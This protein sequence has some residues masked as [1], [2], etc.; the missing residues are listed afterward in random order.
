MDKEKYKVKPCVICAKNNVFN[1][2]IISVDVL[3]ENGTK[4]ISICKACY[5]EYYNENYN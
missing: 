5:D 1:P 4:S 2:A 3:G